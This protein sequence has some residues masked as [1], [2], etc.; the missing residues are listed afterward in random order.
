[1]G[2]PR[3]AKSAAAKPQPLPLATPAEVAV[4]LR[5][6]VRTLQ[7]WRWLSVGPAYIRQG[8]KGGILYDW[9]DVFAWARNNKHETAESIPA[10]S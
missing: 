1:M 3:A 8:E 2:S 7:Q 4:Y 6:S 9:E 10:A 5:V